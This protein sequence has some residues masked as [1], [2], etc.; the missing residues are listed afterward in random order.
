[1][2][3]NTPP[4]QPGN[5]P[6][7]LT[8][9]DVSIEFGGV[10]ALDD[11]GFDVRAVR[12]ADSSDPTALVR[13]RCSTASQGF[14]NRVAVSSPGKEPTSWDCAPMRWHLP[15]SPELFRISLCSAA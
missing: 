9:S 10:T 5:A 4:A 6:V 3:G 7:V 13:P 1:M 15:G 12:S 14:T 11:V 8:L 2:L